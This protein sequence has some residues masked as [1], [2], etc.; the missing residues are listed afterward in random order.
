MVTLPISNQA[1][2]DAI[3]RH[4]ETTQE[5]SRRSHLGASIIG[6]SCSRQLWYTFRWARTQH[7]DGR[8]LKLFRRGHDEEPRL[9]NDLR[10]VGVEV[11]VVDRDT[12][13][14]FRVSEVGGHFGGSMDGCALGVHEAPQTWHVLEFKTSG[15]KPFQKLKKDG[16][17]QAKPE[18]F[19]QMQV[20]M[21]LTGMTRAFY[22]A[23][24]KNDDEIY[25][26]R[27][28]HD[29]A[30]AIRLL[31][32]ARRI[33]EAQNPPERIGDK[34][35]Y[36]CKWCD[37]YGICHD[38]NLPERNCRTCLHSTPEM[39]GHGEWSCAKGNEMG[40]GR[41][42]LECHRFI[43]ALTNMG[44]PTDVDGDNIVYENW[45]DRG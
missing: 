1:T 41:E 42:R 20:Y 40:D 6:R 23:V 14:Q 5:D 38:T 35:W 15:D 45:T 26:E 27:V 28:K 39:H 8:L 2:R 22:M 25:T 17:Q 31:E 36:E 37:Y 7:H 30:A 10:D 16:V 33:I 4:Y 21:H 18:H 11:H 12:G 19:A 29:P 24:N 13:N 9:V 43:P 32:K 34:T 3:Y 44:E